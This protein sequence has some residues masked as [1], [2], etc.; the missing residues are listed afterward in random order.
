MDKAYYY[1]YYDF[2]RK[3]WWFTVR[4]KILMNEIRKKVSGKKLKILN[5]GCATGRST[6]ALSEF[7]Q[8]V[9]LEYDQ[10]CCEFT[11]ERTGLTVIHGSILELPFEKEV[12]DLVC[13][14]DVIEH[15]QDD[16]KGTEEML[17]VCKK[18]GT[19]F[20]SVPA[21]M[22]L[23]SDHDEVNHHYRRYVMKELDSLFKDK[24]GNIVSKSYFNTFLFPAISMVRYISGLFK[25]GASSQKSLKSDF[26]MNA[27]NSPLNYFP[28]FLFSIEKFFLN[29]GI[30]F[31]FGVSIFYMWKKS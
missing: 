21:F 3:H 2:E 23:W 25:S 7:G 1:K 28:L 8:V 14:F 22:S 4:E 9:S 17:R 30:K 27:V 5:I 26:E 13:C 29:S 16:R 20:I 6:E 11:R 15:V 19:I 31:P 10:E 12:F 18:G 24:N